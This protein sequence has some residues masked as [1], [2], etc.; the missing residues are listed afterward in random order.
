MLRSPSRTIG[1]SSTISRR[2][3]G[4]LAKR[5]VPLRAE[6]QGNRDRRPV[7][8]PALDPAGAAEQARTFPHPGEPETAV[9]RA[10]VVIEADAI[11]T[12]LDVEPVRLAAHLDFD[13][14]AAGMARRIDQALLKNAEGRCLDGHRQTPVADPLDESTGPARRTRRPTAGA[15]AARDGSR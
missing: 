14:L 8:A 12:N 1:W 2:I 13:C 10:G 4:S 5:D 3:T 11:I 15:P 9:G 7:P 6:R